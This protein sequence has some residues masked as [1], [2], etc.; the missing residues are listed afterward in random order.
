MARVRW[1]TLGISVAAGTFAA[2]SAR[3]QN[4]AMPSLGIPAANPSVASQANTEPA[5]AAG[6]VVHGAKG[7]RV[8]RPA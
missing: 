4:V 3:A 2:L 1:T 7:D 8:V 6:I 5:G